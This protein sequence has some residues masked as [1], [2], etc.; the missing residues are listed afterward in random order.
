MEDKL[1]YNIVELIELDSYSR[2]NEYLKLGWVLISTHLW[3]YGHPVER[4]QKT[5]YCLGWDKRKGEVK[6]PKVVEYSPYK[7]LIKTVNSDSDDEIF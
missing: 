2:A 1:L 4:D 6:H 3:D 7:H 5:I